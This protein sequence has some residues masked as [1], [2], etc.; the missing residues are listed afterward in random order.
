MITKST[1]IVQPFKSR[2]KDIELLVDY[3]FLGILIFRNRVVNP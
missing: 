1:Y 3:R 2:S